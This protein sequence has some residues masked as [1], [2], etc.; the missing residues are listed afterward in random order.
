MKT[1]QGGIA[2]PR[3]LA[4]AAALLTGLAACD[5]AEPPAAAE[6][7][8]VRVVVVEETQRGEAVSLAGTVESRVQV[9]LGFRIGGRVIERL[10]DVGDVV[11]AGQLLARLDASDEE[12]A[13]RAAE[14]S[15]AAAAGTLAEARI[16]FDRQRQLFERQ[17]AARAALERA[18]QVLTSAQGAYDAAEAQVAIARRRLA[19]TALYADAPGVVVAR[20][21]EPG[22][23][24]GAGRMIVQLARDE[25]MD[26]VFDVPAAVIGAAPP[27]PE[28]T[29]SLSL[30]PSVTAPGRVREIAPRADAVT[31]TFRVRVG[32]HDVPEQMRLGSTVVGRAVFGARTGISLPASALTSAEGEPA[33]W[34]VDPEAGTVSLRRIGVASFEP[35]A[36]SVSD[37][38][39]VGD[40]V[41]T[42]GVQALRPGQQ[43]RL[44]GGG[45]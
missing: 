23:V 16:N 35:A 20:A 33:V 12:N 42:A 40:V 36:V 10:V 18:E 4:L 43:V 15:R 9:D 44:L 5:D 21:A 2:F 25:G 14:A 28:I 6:V 38:L 30:D 11:E 24:V 3:R 27:D 45:S 26:A 41:V 22:E 8:P 39:E 37:G 17:I 7:R 31:G 29:V 32:L 13:L 34:V 19:D 1:I